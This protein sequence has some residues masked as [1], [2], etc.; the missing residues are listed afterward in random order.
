MV[1]W[2]S[3]CLHAYVVATTPC[4]RWA[5]ARSAQRGR[6]PV[7]GLVFHRVANDH[8]NAWTMSTHTFEQQIEWLQEHCD[9]VS[10]TEAQGRIQ[11]GNHERLAVSITFDDGYADNC[12][13]AIPALLS[14]RI[15]FTY[16]VTTHNVQNDRPFPHDLIAGQALSPNSVDEI[17]ALADAGVEI[18]VHTQTHADLGRIA[19]TDKL[20]QEILGARDELEDW[21]GR[22]IR[23][24]AFPYGLPANLNPQ[25][26]QMLHDAGFTGFCSSYGGYNVPG[27]DAFH[28][29]RFHADSDLLRVRNW[30]TLDPRWLWSP[31][32]YEYKLSGQPSLNEE[33]QASPAGKASE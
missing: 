13:H 32:R 29:Q 7:C 17:K 26:V 2:N 16:F 21:T 22:P 4:R 18:G 8:P 28:L 33:T 9:L 6:L 31:L 20:Q 3:L 30:F 24:F 1:A 19:Q 27:G 5:R 11:N 10:L 23:Y 25:A 14:R 15:P 12:L